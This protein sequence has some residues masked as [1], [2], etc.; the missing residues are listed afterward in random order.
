MSGWLAVPI[1]PDKWSSTVLR[2]S[3]VIKLAFWFSG[4]Q[5]LSVLNT[6]SLL[7]NGYRVFPGCK[8]AGAWC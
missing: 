4:L 5:L 3:H 2:V 8:A 1:N 6:F 7:Y